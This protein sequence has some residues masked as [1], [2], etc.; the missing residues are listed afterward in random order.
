[1]A[2]RELRRALHDEAGDLPPAPEG[3]ANLRDY[4]VQ[5]PLQAALHRLPS[6]HS[7]VGV[8][9]QG[10]LCL[11]PLS[12]PSTGW[13][14]HAAAILLRIQCPRRFSEVDPET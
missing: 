4:R 6:L 11:H 1:M 5:L 2:H 9:P 13:F 7:K 12:G 3:A 8:S 14:R 10:V